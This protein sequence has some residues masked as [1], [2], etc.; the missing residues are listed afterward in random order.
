[1]ALEEVE[2]FSPARAAPAAFITAAVGDAS[3]PHAEL[4]LNARTDHL[5]GEDGAL[6]GI[7]N[8]VGWVRRGNAHLVEQRQR[9][10]PV[11]RTRLG[12]KPVVCVADPELVAGI[13]RNEER[14][15]S[16]A[17]AYLAFFH[18]LDPTSPTFDILNAMDFEF[19]RDA[20]KVVQPAFGPAATAG[21][22]EDAQPMFEQA[23][24]GWIAAG[25]VTFK[26][27]IRRLLAD[28]SSRIFLGTDDAAVGAMLD[29]SLQQF[30]GSS[31]A[32]AKVPWFSPAW[33]GGIE[34]YRRMRT[35]FRPLVEERRTGNGR[36]LFSLLCK[37]SRGAHGLDE[38]GVVRVFIGVLA[39][40]FDTTSL[41]LS[42]M[43]YLLARHP[44]WQE[45][46]RDEAFAVS[47]GRISYDDTKRLGA[48]DRAWKETLRLFP[49]APH[50]PRV[51]LRDVQLAEWRIPAGALVL[52]MVAPVLMD[53][54]WWTDPPRFDPDRFSDERAE[55]RKHRGAF[56]PF[57]AGAHAC[58]GLH[59]A[60]VEARAFWHAML[61]RCR[62]RLVKDYEARHSFNLLGV[63]SGEVKLAIERL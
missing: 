27:A 10:G 39:A 9:F 31:F 45:R 40:A 30:W 12:N 54:A 59:L 63:A 29:R 19:H 36:D 21:Y 55:D 48:T 61:T 46:L 3:R 20:R 11:Y 28:V 58:V 49:I 2:A 51:A 41:G 38:D 43:A 62:F 32:L 6:V 60:N 44:E 25:G 1:M 7:R 47:A 5:P 16:T 24:E 33:R 13:A 26:P 57:G 8:L 50:L 34:G 14:A 18:G 37:E 17:L 53:P 35:A 4:P 23:I 42:S 56:V 22:L 52:A 15:W